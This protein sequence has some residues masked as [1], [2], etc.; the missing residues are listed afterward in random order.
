MVEEDK[1]GHSNYNLE[2]KLIGLESEVMAFAEV[3]PCF[4][5]KFSFPRLNLVEVQLLHRRKTS[6][7]LQFNYFALNGYL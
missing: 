7:L 2:R 5:E 4:V 6:F 3:G 1:V